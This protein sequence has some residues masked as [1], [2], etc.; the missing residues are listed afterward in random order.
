MKPLTSL[1]SADIRTLEVIEKEEIMS[2]IWELYKITEEQI[3][4]LE[5]KTRSQAISSLWYE[6]RKGRITASKV[7][8]ILTLKTTTDPTNILTT[9]MGYTSKDISY[10]KPVKWVLTMKK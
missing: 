8:Y 1:Y 10:L 2:Q 7:H 5:E 3:D 6:H 4:I 9:L